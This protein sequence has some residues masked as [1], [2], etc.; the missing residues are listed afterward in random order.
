M[1]Y[2]DR[3]HVKSVK[4]RQGTGAMKHETRRLQEAR[5]EHVMRVACISFTFFGVRKEGQWYMRSLERFGWWFLPS[6]FYGF[7][8]ALQK[9]FEFLVLSEKVP[10]RSSTFSQLSLDCML[11]KQRRFFS[12]CSRELIQLKVQ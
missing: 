12:G 9:C 6:R 1:L 8:R 11:Q 4:C 10:G 7:A 3:H 5:L 2:S